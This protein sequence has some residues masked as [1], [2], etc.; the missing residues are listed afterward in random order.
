MS[1]HVVEEE[2]EET[3][4]FGYQKVKSSEKSSMVQGVFHS[5]AQKYDLMNDLMSLGIHRLWK[6]FAIELSGAR[7]DQKILDLASGTGD[8]AMRF[9]RIVGPQGLVTLTD[10]NASM[11]CVG[12]DRLTD[13]GYT[14]NVEYVQA[15]AEH[16]PFPDNSY[17][18][19]TIS[20]GLRNVTRKQAALNEMYRVLKPGGR[21][22][23]LEFSHPS[24]PVFSKVYD[25]YSFNIL[26]ALGKWI[27]D[28]EE[29]YRYL[30][31]SIRVHPNQET[32]LEMLYTAGFE[33]CDFHNLT[34]GIVA[35]HRGFK[36]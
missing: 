8:L 31:E 24:S 36:L 16:L 13:K 27:V 29:S 35:L 17:N 15:D 4:H 11:L 32:L 33:R 6:R 21:A 20:F 28:D 34:G 10:I 9:S 14:N 22:L 2:T 5:V 18:C 3:T 12:R 1:D 19:V 7:E 30:A 26:P 25:N 23:I